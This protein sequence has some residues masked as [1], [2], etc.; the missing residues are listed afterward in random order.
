MDLAPPAFSAAD[1]PALIARLLDPSRPFDLYFCVQ[2]RG[3]ERW[4]INHVRRTPYHL[5]YIPESDPIVGQVDGVPVRADPG[6]V[7]WVQPFALW[8]ICVPAPSGGISLGVMRF[9]LPDPAILRLPDSFRLGR[10]PPG[11]L[12][13]AELLPGHEVGAGLERMRQ[14][15]VIARLL[16]RAFAGSVA[17]EGGDGLRPAVRRKLLDWMTRNIRGRFG[18]HDLARVAEMNPQYL[19]RRFHAAF[20]TAPKTWIMRLRVRHA[21]SYLLASD[22]DIAA[23]ATR[24]GYDSVFLFSRQFRAVMDMSPSE[25]RRRNAGG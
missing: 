4:R 8:D 3:M 12:P 16:C 23:V 2:E 10:R 18:I 5:I 15:S 6:M 11:D 20:G 24:F 17:E 7:L 9:D 1:V 22:D 19:S 14:R 13:L 21:A 25:W